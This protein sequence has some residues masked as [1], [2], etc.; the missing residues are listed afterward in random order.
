M[1]AGGAVSSAT[2]VAFDDIA[3]GPRTQIIVPISDTTTY[4]FDIVDGLVTEVSWGENLGEG[5]PNG[6]LCAL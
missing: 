4:N 5:G 6:D 1:I 3:R 2:E